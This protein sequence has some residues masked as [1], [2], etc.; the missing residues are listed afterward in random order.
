VVYSFAAHPKINSWENYESMNATRQIRQV[1]T[2]LCARLIGPLRGW[3]FDAE[4]RRLTSLILLLNNASNAHSK[5][6][7]W[8]CP[9]RHNKPTGPS[10]ISSHF[11]F[12]GEPR[13]CPVGKHGRP[14]TASSITSVQCTRGNGGHPGHRAGPACW[15]DQCDVSSSALT[16]PERCSLPAASF[17]LYRS[18]TSTLDRHSASYGEA[19]IHLW[20]REL[21]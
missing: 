14:G 6:G 13:L 8:P 4:A 2:G 7:F 20:F 12:L 17:T 10:I 19:A 9:L 16:V 3:L 18:T 11:L 21:T 5:R 15:L 1:K